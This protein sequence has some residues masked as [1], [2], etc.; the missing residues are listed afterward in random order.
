[1][2][3]GTEKDESF[4]LRH[5]L[6]SGVVSEVP[7][8]HIRAG[9]G[10]GTSETDGPGDLRGVR[11]RDS[12]NGDDEGPY[13]SSG[14][15]SA[16]SVDRGGRED[17][18]EPERAGV[19][20]RVPGA[21]KEALG[22]GVVGRRIFRPDSRRPNDSGRDSQV[23]RATSA[24]RARACAAGFEAALL[25]APRLAAGIFTVDIRASEH[26]FGSPLF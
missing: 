25:N 15:V 26:A 24:T 22:R 23:Y 14:V 1:M 16:V 20:S 3:R 18:Q 4:G 13:T 8:G 11:H 9:G 10:P 6:P 17:H 19:V 21:Q 7:E 12:G 5:E 2:N